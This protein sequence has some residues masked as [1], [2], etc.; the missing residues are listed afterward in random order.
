MDGGHFCGL[1]GLPDGGD[2][3]GGGGVGRPDGVG[4]VKDGVVG[5]GTEIHVRYGI[6]AD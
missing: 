1:V 5:G 2:D 4:L 6:S 3:R